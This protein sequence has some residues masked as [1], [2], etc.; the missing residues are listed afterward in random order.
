MID[1]LI[2]QFDRFLRTVAAP[3]PHAVR[4]PAMP[5]D[6]HETAPQ[7]L[8]AADARSGAA[9]AAA[10]TTEEKHHAA[11]LMRVNHAGEIAAQALYAGQSLFARTPEM[12]AM[13]KQAAQEEQD[14]L[15]WTQA[16]LSEL[17]ARPSVFNPLWYAGAFA[18]GAASAALG[19]KASLGFLKATENQVEAHLSEHLGRL[20]AHDARSRAIVDAMRADEA[21]HA[22]TA[23]AH[24][25]VELPK[26]IRGAMA[27]SA[28]VMTTTAYYV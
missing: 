2:T 27:L 26:P 10:L 13:L 24:G 21:Q 16:R 1:T 18:L 15:S 17:G 25:A 14:H 19:D 7:V 8:L 5:P 6:I 9:P 22:Q 11:G 23:V 3:A 20:P 28:K 12:K 4:Q